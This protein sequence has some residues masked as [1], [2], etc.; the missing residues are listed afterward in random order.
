MLTDEK[1]KNLYKMLSQSGFAKFYGLYEDKEIILDGYMGKIPFDGCSVIDIL[2]K[3]GIVLILHSDVHNNEGLPSSRIFEAVAASTVIISDQ[4][5][6]VKQHFGDS[7]FYI[8]TSLA[9]EEI[10]MQIEKH[11]EVILL[12][13][14]KALQMAEKA[15]QIFTDNF[16]LTDQL[17]QLEAMNR[18]IKS[19]QKKKGKK[20]FFFI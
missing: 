12:A 7:V 2:Q 3:H 1:Y 9:A 15:H 11:M 16:L 13:P 20:W 5:P 19:S 18:E 10:Y 17:L 8:D 14:E 4:N 6:F